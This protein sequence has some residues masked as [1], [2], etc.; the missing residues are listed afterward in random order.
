M[1]RFFIFLIFLS[2]CSFYIFKVNFRKVDKL[3]EEKKY[4][5]AIKVLKNFEKRRK[6]DLCVKLKLA[7]VYWKMGI[8]D[9]AKKRYFEILKYKELP[10]CRKRLSYIYEKEGLYDRARK[11]LEIY[12]K[13]EKDKKEYL[14]LS[15]LYEKIGFYDEAIKLLKKFKDLVSEEEYIE[16]I[17]FLLV[18]QN[19]IEEAYEF[20]K[21]KDNKLL[22]GYGIILLGRYDEAK[23]FLRKDNSRVSKFLLLLIGKIK[24]EKYSISIQPENEIERK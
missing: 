9:E 10:L 13:N 3:I 23:E 16:R 21:E 2:S 4:E 22:K 5:E 17:F 7:E 24:G 19:K 18:K 20:V 11:N 1:K 12:L 6:R 15:I 8:Y 14:H